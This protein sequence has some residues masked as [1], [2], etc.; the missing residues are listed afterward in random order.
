MA[1]TQVK[2]GE[3]PSK[4]AI[5]EC[6]ST[7]M[8]QPIPREQAELLA[9]LLKAVADPVRLQLLSLIGSCEEVCACDLYEP[10][11]LSQ[12]T[13]SHH[14]KVLQRAG[15]VEREQRGTWAWFSVNRKR[16]DDLSIL[17]NS[18]TTP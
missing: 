2:I 15:L 1:Q 16:M 14:L 5:A 11:G 7:G 9:Q 17:F 4:D 8:A 3:R 10:V 6:C 13:V 12:P 18:R